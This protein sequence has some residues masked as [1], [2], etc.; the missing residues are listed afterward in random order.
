M[1]ELNKI[2]QGDCL[3]LLKQIDDNSIDLVFTDPPYNISQKNKIFRNYKNGK[4]A[5]IKMNFGDWDYNFNIVSF[6]EESKRVLKENGSIIV[7]TSE[8]LVGKYRDWFEK[9]MYPEQLLIWVKSNPLPQFRLIGYRQATELMFWALKNKNTKSNDNFNFSS[10]R[11]MTN[12]FYAPIVGGKERTEHPTQ[13]PLSITEKII[14][15]HCKKEGIVLDPFLG[16]GTTAVAC[17]KLGRHWIGIEREEEYCKIAEAR[18]NKYKGQS[19][20]I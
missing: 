6:L 7:W 5:D 4:N 11:E 12:V 9:E 17:E 20:L 14:K 2:H 3:E 1:L 10:Q 13:K 15:T 16:S 19:R 8:Q 18:I